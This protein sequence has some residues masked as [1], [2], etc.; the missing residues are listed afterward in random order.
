MSYPDATSA[1]RNESHKNLR[2]IFEILS[3]L[4]EDARRDGYVE[5]SARLEFAM[6][7]AEEN[8]RNPIPANAVQSI[9]PS[10]G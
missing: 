6:N 10:G 7:N 2:A 3:Y 9:G 8:L 1:P 4:Q 5:L